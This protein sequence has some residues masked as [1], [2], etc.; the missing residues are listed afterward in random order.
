MKK[1]LSLVLALVLCLC[2]C[3]ASLAEAQPTDK[4]GGMEMFMAMMQMIPG[5]EEIDWEGFYTAFTEKQAS[6]AEITLEDCLPAEAW[7]LFGSMM[8]GQSGTEESGAEEAMTAEVT[9]TGNVM[10]M[11]Y[12]M[13]KQ[14]DEAGTKQIAESVAA[15]F[16]SP[17]SLLNLKSSIESMAGA[18]IN[19]SEVSMTLKF[20]NADDSVIYEKTITYDDVKGLEP[21]TANAE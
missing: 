7:A 10:V 14:V 19:L 4:E 13:K 12:K 21:A 20:V 18:G 3:G 16:E 9:V 2:F 17:E 8:A 1:M 6:G 15:S 5:M 11:T